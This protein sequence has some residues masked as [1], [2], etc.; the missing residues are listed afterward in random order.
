M[1]EDLDHLPTAGRPAIVDS[2]SFAQEV[3]LTTDMEGPWAIRSRLCLEVTKVNYCEH[4]E[5]SANLQSQH[6]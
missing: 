2:L 4:C 1:H 5:R 3:D 6:L